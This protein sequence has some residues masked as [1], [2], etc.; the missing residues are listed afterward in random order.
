MFL[1]KE[2]RDGLDFQNSVL[3]CS[4]IY[5]I[6]NVCSAH[7]NFHSLQLIQDR[8]KVVPIKISFPVQPLYYVLI[9]GGV[10]LFVLFCHFLLYTK[11]Q[12]ESFPSKLEK[13]SECRS[14]LCWANL[15]FLVYFCCVFLFFDLRE[16]SQSLSPSWP[17]TE[18]PFFM[19]L[20]N[21]FQLDF[22]SS[23]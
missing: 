1:T 7:L 4:L 8:N 2:W 14:H 10:V 6:V 23:L 18:I 19:Y 12:T 20:L 9:G 15:S 3:W 16:W 21:L 22:G 11:G 5:Y 13:T 17:E